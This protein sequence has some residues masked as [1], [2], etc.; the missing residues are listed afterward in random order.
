MAIPTVTAVTFEHHSSG[1]GLDTPIPRLSWR[2][3]T[4]SSTVDAWVQTSYEVE[5]TC[6]SEPKAKV[7]RVDSNQSILV[8]WPARPLRSRQSAVVRVRVWGKSRSP[9][10]ASYKGDEPSPWSPAATVEAA[11]LQTTDF[12][13]NFIAAA[14]RPGPWGPLRPIRFRKEFDLPNDFQSG[15]RARLYVTA[16]GLFEAWINGQR[17]GDEFLAP[18]WTSYKHRLPYRIHD[19]TPLLSP[20]RK[21]V[22][23]I[24]VAEGWYA[25]RLGFQPG[26][27]FIYGDELGIYVQLEV[28]G[29]NN[30]VK[31]WTLVSDNS[32]LCTASAILSAEI[33]DGEVYDCNEEMVG[34]NAT[35]TDWLPSDT[36]GTKILPWPTAKLVA[37]EAPPIRITETVFCKQVLKS[38]SGKTILDF[39]QN[40]VG[41]IHIPSLTLA[42][43]Q[44]ILLRHAEVLENGELGSRPL[45]DAKARDIIIGSGQTLHNWSPKFTY[46]GFRYVEVTGWPE[47]G[48]P[49]GDIQALVM[50]SD[51][52]RRGYFSCSNSYVNQLH[53]NVVWSMRGNFMSLPTDCPQRDERL[54][55]TGDIQIFAPTACF[56]YDTTSIL[57]NWLQ[58]VAAEQLEDGNAGIPPLVV[59]NVLVDWP[60][61]AQSIWDDV[62]VLLP[63]HLYRYSS[64]KLLLKRQFKSMQTW[65]DEGVD[66]AP[67]GFWHPDKWQL[68]DWLDPSAP[69]E[70]PGNGRTDS[71]LV[72]NAYLIHTTE[73]FSRLCEV[74]GMADLAAKYAKEVDQL[75]QAFQRRYLT[76]EGNLMSTSQ[77]G[78]ALAVQFGLYPDDTARGTASGALERLVRNARFNIGTGFA[79]T[80]VISHALTTIGKP[81][82][83]Y[84]MLLETNCPSWLYPVVHM[85]AT[86]IWERWDSML[87]DKSINPGS[88]TSFNHYALGAVADWLHVSVGGISPLEPGW[89]VVRVRPVPGGNIKNARVSF[90][91]PYGWIACEWVLDGDRFNMSLTVPPNTS[92]MVT[93][94]SDLRTDYN[95]GDE[96]THEVY[97]GKHTFS[98]VFK[99]A[100]WPPKPTVARYMSMPPDSIAE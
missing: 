69:P 60:H 50:H 17:V 93:L 27:P 51:M 47:K 10:A 15:H 96:V 74:L 13:A 36:L 9:N 46:H 5:V 2:F 39:G 67:D 34:W 37:L 7:C 6:A 70:D 83:A 45:Q 42:K 94:P 58:D 56:L 59:P 12:R 77:T 87:P 19:V 57:S 22:I 41:K 75:K 31:P 64:D 30:N 28:E 43:G 98:C 61:F 66:R 16:F 86:T 40:L 100:Q 99:T 63:N 44:Q 52:R 95:I 54:G 62:T 92:A 18:G 48:P 25:G 76:P 73:V 21:N 72:A 89:R 78:I 88:M 20:N 4:T 26:H 3:E 97:S 91:G 24:E 81:Q 35:D 8:P 49:P 79:G 32:W 71:I 1:L 53:N 55:W 29:G 82:L 68:G 23:A 33:Y 65:L 85:G 80:P 14:E 90:D 11:L 84:R 38:A